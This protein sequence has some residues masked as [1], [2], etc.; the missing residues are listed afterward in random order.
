[1]IN[2]EARNA[3]SGIKETAILKKIISITLSIILCFGLL[4]S[5]PS[6]LFAEDN[7]QSGIPGLT[8]SNNSAAGSVIGY[9]GNEWWVIGY[10]DGEGYS[11]GI[12]SSPSNSVTLFAKN[13]I[14]GN[15]AFNSYGHEYDGSALQY[16]LLNDVFSTFPAKEVVNLINVRDLYNFTGDTDDYHGG[17]AYYQPIWPISRLEWEALYNSSDP[18]V[19][20]F[21]GAKYWSRSGFEGDPYMAHRAASSPAEFGNYWVNEPFPVRP[22]L[23]FSLDTVMFTSIASS[24][25][26][27][28]TDTWQD[29]QTSVSTSEPIKFTMK[30][31]NPSYALDE[32]TATSVV[33]NTINFDYSISGSGY[34]RLSAMIK[35]EDGIIKYYA[36]LVDYPESEGSASVTIPDSLSVALTDSLLIFI[37]KVDTATY[38]DFAG[39]PMRITWGTP[40]GLTGSSA[41]S[42]SES[43]GQIL[44]TTTYMEYSSDGSTW[45]ACTYEQTE[46]LEAGAYQIRYAALS[47]NGLVSILAGPTTE[48]SVD[49]APESSGS[50]SLEPPEPEPSPEPEPEP[51]PEPEPSPEPE[52]V[53]ELE[54]SPEPEPIPELEPSPEPE[55][56]PEL[57]SVPEP[58]PI[59]EQ[60]SVS[61]P[62]PSPEPE[63][64]PELASVPELEPVLEQE[65]V[66]EPEPVHSPEPTRFVMSALPPDSASESISVPRPESVLEPGYTPDPAPSRYLVY[67]PEPAPS[68]EPESEPVSEPEPVPEPESALTSEY[69]PQNIAL[70][71]QEV[72]KQIKEDGVTI[73]TIGSMEIPLSG[74]PKMSQYVWALINLT[75][76][77]SGIILS[78]I[79][80]ARAFLNKKY[81]KDYVRY[82]YIPAGMKKQKQVRSIWLTI[83]IITG[84]IGI[85]VFIY[86]ENTT[87]L[88]VLLDNWT[89]INTAIL[90]LG[91]ISYLFAFKRSKNA[92]DESPDY[93]IN[94]NNPIGASMPAAKLAFVNKIAKFK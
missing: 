92:G 94:G 61:E 18:A 68:P 45:S 59:P 89:V 57:A 76:A 56:V 38:S 24:G 23:N 22:A 64:V 3:Y 90:G 43:D 10:N 40:T 74:G 31:S 47:I 29:M 54:P 27:I 33:D 82:S 73:I 1:M 67:L 78:L 60:E 93:V 28:S 21:D 26:D 44:D 62:E 53:P 15:S 20:N 41:S 80:A 75:C 86:T 42:D 2:Y 50:G 70:T 39:E 65:S 83:A 17:T 81:E 46:D 49:V 87:K 77:V 32:L 55:F 30:D 48:V 84:I 79:A 37:E 69:I 51:I 5:K 71:S 91:V 58:E 16:Y 6:P 85:A 34:N 13:N 19:V 25:K 88:M 52:S 63:F 4:Y 36:N 9:A 14:Y 35:D 11:A 8:V 66:P 12:F 7:I 72:M